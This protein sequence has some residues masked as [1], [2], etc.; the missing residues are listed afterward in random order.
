MTENKNNSDLKIKLDELLVEI[1]ENY[2]P[3][4]LEELNARLEKTITEFNNDINTIFKESFNKS[5]TIS[6]IVSESIA[7]GSPP[8]L[9]NV[10]KDNY[11][12]PKYLSQKKTSKN[13]KNTVNNSEDNGTSKKKKKRRLFS[14]KK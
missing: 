8:D 10:T 14:R 7:S 1:E 4:M 5:N 2:G 9:T 6:K 12:T 3:V 11:N 13:S